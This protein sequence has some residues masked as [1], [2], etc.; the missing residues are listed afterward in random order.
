[1][2]NKTTARNTGKLAAVVPSLCIALL[3]VG[4][5]LYGMFGSVYQVYYL[6]E[7]SD[8]S[9]FADDIVD[10]TLVMSDSYDGPYSATETELV[11]QS[12]FGGFV[13]NQTDPDVARHVLFKTQRGADPKACAT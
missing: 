5:L 12:T 10:S 7:E 2:T 13:R 4:V 8:A 1:V 6:K 9:Y 11:E 3:S